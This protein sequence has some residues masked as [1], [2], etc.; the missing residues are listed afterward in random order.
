MTKNPIKNFFLLVSSLFVVMA[1]PSVSIAESSYS[2]SGATYE[3]HLRMIAHNPDRISEYGMRWVRDYIVQTLQ[4]SGY[5]EVKIQK[6]VPKGGDLARNII[7]DL[8]GRKTRDFVVLAA[9]YDGSQK[10]AFEAN[11]ATA[12]ASLLTIA[13]SMKQEGFVGEYGVRFLF[14]DSGHIRSHHAS[15]RQY[16]HRQDTYSEWGN[17]KA[18]TYIGPI[19]F[20]PGGDLKVSL[21]MDDLGGSTGFAKT[22]QDAAKSNPALRKMKFQSLPEKVG[23]FNPLFSA[24]DS[25]IPSIDIREF[26]TPIDGKPYIYPQAG[27][28]QDRIESLNL[29]YAVQVTQFIREA[30]A[31]CAN[32]KGESSWLTENLER[33]EDSRKK[34]YGVKK[35]YWDENT[36]VADR[37]DLSDHMRSRVDAISKHAEQVQKYR[38]QQ[39]AKRKFSFRRFFR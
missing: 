26:T 36:E 27:T 20:S 19:G 39:K 18:F 13:Q 3:Q 16:F 34:L 4:S 37:T 1:S 24:W 32:G 2:I 6:Y 7:V 5:N 15:A 14:M 29:D 35:K 30:A 25:G 11:D 33:R 10:M 17:L 22:I 9:T 8:P 28:A 21:G 38:E 31:S 12:V 23:G